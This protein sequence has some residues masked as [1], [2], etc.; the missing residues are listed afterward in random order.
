MQGSEKKKPPTSQKHIH[1]ANKFKK[2]ERAKKKG[3]EKTNPTQNAINSDVNHKG[4]INSFFLFKQEETLKTPIK[5]LR[6]DKGWRSSRKSCDQCISV[7]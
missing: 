5:I 1:I 6:Q 4:E 3:R 7:K 2:K